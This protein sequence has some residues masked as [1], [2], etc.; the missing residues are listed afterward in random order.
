LEVTAGRS[1]VLG[2]PWAF[3]NK[4]VEKQKRAKGDKGLISLEI[5]SKREKGS[6]AIIKIS[7]LRSKIE[8]KLGWTRVR[9]KG[10]GKHP[11]Y[12]NTTKEGGTYAKEGGV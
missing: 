12:T 11:N 7:N 1:L 4:R 9:E 6:L 8:A 2:E 3:W 5:P 10:R